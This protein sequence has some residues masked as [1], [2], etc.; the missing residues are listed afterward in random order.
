MAKWNSQE[1]IFI[2]ICDFSIMGISFVN[3]FLNCQ[4]IKH[5]YR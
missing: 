3:N 1:E 5:G 2:P 4:M